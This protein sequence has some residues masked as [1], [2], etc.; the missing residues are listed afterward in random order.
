MV[1]SRLCWILVALVMKLKGEIRDYRAHLRI[2]LG[3]HDYLFRSS[4]I[5]SQLRADPTPDNPERG[6]LPREWRPDFANAF[7]QT[8][9]NTLLLCWLVLWSVVIVV[10]A[11]LLPG[12][13]KLLTLPFCYVTVYSAIG[14]P[15]AN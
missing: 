7:H 2:L 1:V 6:E 11:S 9:G 15:R 3:P 4:S 13:N 5:L 14:L 8:G 12:S 10:Y